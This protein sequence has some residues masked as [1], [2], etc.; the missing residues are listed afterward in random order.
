MKS[1]ILALAVTCL[2]G[3]SPE[4]KH[5]VSA[6]DIASALSMH[7]WLIKMPDDCSPNDRL[8]LKVIFKDEEKVITSINADPGEVT[9][10]LIWNNDTKGT[11]NF[12]WAK[13]K[14]ANFGRIKHHAFTFSSR[15]YPNTERVCSVG[16]IILEGEELVSDGEKYR[17]EICL[18]TK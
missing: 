8:S 15:I 16:D 1:I 4:N 11:H 9:R 6:Q 13:S 5:A 10:L 17:V 14:S 12:H 18:K 7:K 3:C 2:V